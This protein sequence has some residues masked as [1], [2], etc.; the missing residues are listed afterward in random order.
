MA[1]T[2]MLT[3]ILL[4][5]MVPRAAAAQVPM[6]QVI[7]DNPSVRIMLVT[8]AP[9]VASGRHQGIEAEVGILVDGDL[10]LESPQGRVMLRPGTAYWL[11]GLTPHDI[12]N[13]SQRP[14]RM[15][16]ILLKRCD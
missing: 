11:P 4:V 6:T 9:G 16:D 7:L 13:E 12:R 15:Y 2:L 3:V 14:A 10:T 5:T 1:K 8:V